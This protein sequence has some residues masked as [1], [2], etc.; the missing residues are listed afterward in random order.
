VEKRLENPQFNMFTNAVITFTKGK[1]LITAEE[2]E[3]LKHIRLDDWFSCKSGRIKGSAI[4]EIITISEY[5]NRFPKEQ[6]EEKKLFI[7][8]SK[9]NY[10]SIE[11][12]AAKDEKN[13]SSLLSGLKKYCQENPNAENAKKLYEKKLMKFG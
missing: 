11:D 13:L 8:P 3:K 12:M 6:P 4:A 1:I 2:N 9:E 10:E 5:Y 7:A